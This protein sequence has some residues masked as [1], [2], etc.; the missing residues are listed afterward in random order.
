MMVMVMMMMM[1]MMLV[2]DDVV[3]PQFPVES[4]GKRTLVQAL[5][6]QR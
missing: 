4:P 3:N 5:S 6:V 1:M 2:M